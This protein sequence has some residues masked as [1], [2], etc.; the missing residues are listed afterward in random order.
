MRSKC[1]S[2]EISLPSFSICRSSPS[3]ICWVKSINVSRMRKLRSCTAIL[4]ACMY[5]QSPA[6]TH[7]ELPHCVFAAGRP[8]RIWASSI[9]SSCLRGKLSICAVVRELHVDSEI[10][11]A[12]HSDHFL[13]CVAIFTAHPHQIS[14]DRGLHFFL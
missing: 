10:L 6:S 2:S 14:L 9:M 3:T 12:Q 8:R 13:E 7:F 5:S 11:L 1:S 4:N